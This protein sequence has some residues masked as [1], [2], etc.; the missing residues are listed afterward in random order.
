MRDLAV[1]DI[2]I[3]VDE[4][5]HRDEWK[6]GRIVNTNSS[7]GHVRKVSVR[8]ADGKEVERDRTKVVR[9]ELDDD[10]GDVRRANVSSLRTMVR[11]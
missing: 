10:D 3:L 9:L 1:D 5:T 6:L 4:T 11:S 7:D 8:R 2:V